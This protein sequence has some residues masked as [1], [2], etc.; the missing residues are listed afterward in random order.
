M[1]SVMYFVKKL[2]YYNMKNNYN[3]GCLTAFAEIIVTL[4][5]MFI[6]SFFLM[7]CWNAVIPAVFGLIS[8]TYWQSFCLLFVVRVLMGF[9]SVSF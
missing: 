8:L 7:L 4:V 9:G 3:D 5:L 2:I 1:N 6:M